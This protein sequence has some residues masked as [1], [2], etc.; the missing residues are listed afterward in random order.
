M[1]TYKIALIGDGVQGNRYKETLTHFDNV[2][3]TDMDNGRGDWQKVIDKKPDG[4]IIAC[5]PSLNVKIIN[6]ANILGIPVLVEK[7]VSLS[8]FDLEKLHKAKIP[9]LVNYSMLFTKGYIELK[10]QV[11]KEQI[12]QLVVI[13]CN[14]G[15]FRDYSSLYDYA[16]HN[17]AVCFDLLDNLEIVEQKANRGYNGGIQ[18]GVQLENQNKQ[19]ANML[20][21]NGAGS[22][23]NA[24]F[25]SYHDIT[26]FSY[27]DILDS[28]DRLQP[29]QDLVRHFL[30]VIDGQP[31]KIPWSLTMKIQKALWSLGK[32]YEK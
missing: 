16:P 19:K 4:V 14:N 30:E 1:T 3:L 7:P 29:M 18:Y 2:I 12:R 6:Y 15:P 25:V 31:V 23:H 27:N 21:G 24:V 11:K 13:N 8:L 10:E 17:L 32:N 28:K 20:A 5:H 26:S 22:R 9:I